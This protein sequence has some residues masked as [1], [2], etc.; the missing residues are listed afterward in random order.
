M[1][2]ERGQ[3]ISELAIAWLPFNKR[4][5]S[6]LIGARTEGQLMENIMALGKSRDFEE[7]EIAVI[8]K[9]YPGNL[10]GGLHEKTT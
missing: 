9:Y 3:T 2:I 6:V 5:T 4:V 7:S 10:E 1:A 8:N